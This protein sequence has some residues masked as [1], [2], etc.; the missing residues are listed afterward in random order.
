M[1]QIFR[2]T[3]SPGATG[4]V[5]NELGGLRCSVSY[6]ETSGAAGAT[7][8]LRGPDGD[9]IDTIA[10][11]GLGLVR[12]KALTQIIISGNGST[13]IV[14]ARSEPEYIDPTYLSLQGTG[15]V[16]I[17]QVSGSTPNL[18]R[19]TGGVLSNISSYTDS[20]Y[21]QLTVSPFTNGTKPAAGFVKYVLAGSGDV[22]TCSIG[23]TAYDLNAGSSLASGVLLVGEIHVDG[24]ADIDFGGATVVTLTAARGVGG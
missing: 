8:T 2:N 14:D 6:R 7:V 4:Y 21:G 18:A 17:A 19:E 5:S 22:P 23:G 20:T 15:N 9:S 13:V 3:I 16:N 24:T 10:A 11:S 12:G 1:A